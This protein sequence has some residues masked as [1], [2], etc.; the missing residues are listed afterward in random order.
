LK[1]Y[2]FDARNYDPQIARWHCVDQLSEQFISNSPYHYSYNNPISFIDPDG[3]SATLS[4]FNHWSSSGL[5]GRGADGGN[6]SAETRELLYGDDDSP[7]AGSGGEDDK[8][9]SSSN[10]QSKT[11]SKAG[12]KINAANGEDDLGFSAGPS[13]NTSSGDNY[14]AGGVGAE[15]RGYLTTEFGKAMFDNY[16]FSH[17][18]VK[19]TTARFNDIVSHAGRVLSSDPVTLSNGQAGVAQVH[20]FYGNNP[21]AAVLGSATIFYQGG[22]PVG[23]QDGYDF[24]WRWMWGEGSRTIPNELKTRAVSV[25]GWMHG[26]TPFDITY[27]IRP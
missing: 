22:N 26:A 11:Q 4:G 16:W 23:F 17:G 21:Y 10:K 18:N 24:N 20:S 5:Y 3:R 27:G 25:A 2:D 14:F 6:L 15:I 9:K 12:E 8:K 19:L 13:W 1:W 7:S